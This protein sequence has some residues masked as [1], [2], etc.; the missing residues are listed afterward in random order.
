MYCFSCKNN[1]EMTADGRC[2]RC[3]ATINVTNNQNTVNSQQSAG[4][5][6]G[7][8][9]QY[10]SSTPSKAKHS[11]LAW[12][13]LIFSCT[14]ILSIVGL[15]LGIIALA[16]KDG[17]KKVVPIISIA[18]SSL[19]L[20]IFIVT[21]SG[22]KSDTSSAGTER[23]VTES[24]EL[25]TSVGVPSAPINDNTIKNNETSGLAST[26]ENTSKSTSVT[27]GA[28]TGQKQ[29]Y[30][31]AQSYLDMM[32]FSYKGLIH[33]LEFEKFST[34][35]ATWAADH[36]G[37][38]WNEQAV[39]K[40][41][42]YLDL[43]GYSYDGLIDQLEFEGFTTEQATY[44]ADILYG[45]SS[46]GTTGGESASGGNVSQEN[47]LS[48][49]KSYLE[50]AAFS[51]NGLIDQLEYEGFSTEDATYA[52]D[53]CGA[54]WME[55]AAKKAKSYLEFSS[56]SKQGLI[57]QLEYEGFTHEQAVYGAEQNGF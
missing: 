53:N 15:I 13:S 33:Q 50:F 7:N 23:A 16:K 36:C 1:V 57:E 43:M 24:S 51:Y 10:R 47:A 6:Q 56:F 26:A 34:E 49:A 28:T 39:K 22:S 18:I 3:G 21:P 14:F 37:A 55:Q 35:D 42:S 8:P 48:K 40:G 31:K 52:V 38:D 30:R 5:S 25:G 20:L 9:G 27:D 12:V 17:R 44:A 45:N 46:S 2:P 4:S 41:E 19:F 11:A 32:P 54:N 29:A